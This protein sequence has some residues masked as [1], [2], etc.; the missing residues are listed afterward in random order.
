MHTTIVHVMKQIMYMSLAETSIEG[1]K[2]FNSVLNC[3]KRAD[4]TRNAL[5]VLQRYRFLFNLPKSI[6]M[7]IKNV[8]IWSEL[9]FT[10]ICITVS[11]KLVF[12]F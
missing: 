9:G 10:T 12:I 8:R 4:V 7:N 1:E 11:M 6:E 3:K 5:S 2:I